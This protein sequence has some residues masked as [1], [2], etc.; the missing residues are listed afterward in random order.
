[1]TFDLFITHYQTYIIDFLAFLFF[2]TFIHN[3]LKVL[4]RIVIVRRFY[5]F[6]L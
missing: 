6:N 1:M 4:K 5:S 2:L 3:F